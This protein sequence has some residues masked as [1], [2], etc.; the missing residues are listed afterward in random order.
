MLSYGGRPLAEGLLVLAALL[1]IL[2]LV[3]DRYSLV[4]SLKAVWVDEVGHEPPAVSMQSQIPPLGTRQ[5]PNIV[6]H[7]PN[8]AHAG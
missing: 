8:C 1:L 6:G 3:R 2:H 4:C 5:A 7:E